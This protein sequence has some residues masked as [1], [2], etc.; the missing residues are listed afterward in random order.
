[1]PLVLA[2]EVAGEDLGGTHLQKWA[3]V[4][5]QKAMEPNVVYAAQRGKSKAAF[6]DELVL[7]G[8]GCFPPAAPRRAG[9]G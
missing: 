7:A 4:L 6:A 9:E 8:E 5:Q 1:M 3:V 2:Q